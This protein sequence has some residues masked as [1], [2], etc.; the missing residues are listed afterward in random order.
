MPAGGNTSHPSSMSKHVVILGGGLAGLSCG[1]ELQKAGQRVT[2]LER[3]PFVGGMAASFVEDGDEYWSYDFGPHRFHSK[4]ENLIGHVKE[5]LGDNVVWAQ[6]LSRIFLFNQLIEYP[7]VAGD[8][9]KK[10]PKLMMVKAMLDYL[11]VRIQDRLRLRKFSDDDFESWVV[12]RYGWTLYRVFFGEYTEKTWGMS[13]KLISA[14][15]ASQRITL[16]NL[17]DTIKKTLRPPSSKDGPRTLVREFIYPKLGGIGELARGYARRI[18]AMGGTVLVNAP[19][20]RV[21]RDGS[22]VTGVEYGKHRRETITGDEYVNTIPVTSMVKALS[23]AAPAEILQ[24]AESLRHL[25]IVFVYLK[26]NRDS[27][28]PDNWV[29]LPEKSL[30]VHRFS[31]FKNFSPHCAPKGKTLV[32]CEITC[33][34]GDEIWRASVEQLS[35]IA[36]RDLLKVGLI[37]P[38][39][40]LGAVVK[41]IP[42]AYPVY[43]IGHEKSLEPMM[44][45]VKGLAN[46]RST[47]RQGAF[48]YNNMDQS[49]EM[50]RKLAWELAT[51]AATGHSAVATGKEYFG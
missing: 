9:L 46:L 39:Q 26:L 5:I 20:V 29:Y 45:Y 38:G 27:V 30:T 48:R 35:A 34:R 12:R 50:G 28:S 43:E 10:M 33:K 25:S 19:A 15:W 18:E 32:C 31:E 8:V 4:D 21:F 42:Y 1:Y 24:A 37:E 23:P 47:G 41:K 14:T 16:L 2:V 6:R 44:A 13:P 49:V 3:E 22:K 7:L 36:E 51:G 17:W 40:V 11:W